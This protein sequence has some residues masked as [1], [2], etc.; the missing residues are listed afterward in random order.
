M[1]VLTA[2][3]VCIYI[4]I[5]GWEVLFNTVA[6]TT[7]ACLATASVHLEISTTAVVNMPQMPQM[8]QVETVEL[9]LES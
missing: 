8:P 4:D 1:V 6:N 3:S 9:T 2:L 5:D 7:S